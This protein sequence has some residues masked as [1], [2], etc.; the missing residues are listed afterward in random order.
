[1]TTAI[2]SIIDT[3]DQFQIPTYNKLP[4]ALTHG[5]DCYVWDS[6]GRKYLDFY[7]GHCVTLLGHCPPRVVSAIQ[8]QATDLIFYSNV[9]YSPVR[10]RAAETLANVMPAGMGNIFFCNSGTEANETALKLARTFTGRNGVIAMRGG[11]HGRSLGS[12]SATG[13][14]KYRKPYL[15]ILPHTY[16]VDF[17]DENAVAD[18]LKER[19]D[20]AALILEPI[21]SMAGMV[22]APDAYYRKLRR[23]CDEHGVVLIFDEV[24]TGVGRTGTFSFSQQLDMQPDIVTM[25][26]SLASGM[27]IGAT[28]VSDAIAQTVKAG[29]HGSTFGGGMMSMAALIATIEALNENDL[30]PRASYIFDMISKGIGDMVKHIRG[31]GCLI[32]VELEHPV[33]PKIAALRHQGV[34]V[35]SSSNPNV[36]RLMPPINTPDDA[37]EEFIDAFRK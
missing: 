24:Q 14:D 13:I 35:G 26:K 18:T 6:E 37:V 23:H 17:G 9:A 7:G 36:M 25:A 10:A 20:I 34:L 2:Q 1:M 28:I 15:P 5:K 19:K 8:E 22:D 27:P 29:D 31:R 4:I 11:F 32:G 12:L 30:L 16:F 33:G 3:E 21:Q